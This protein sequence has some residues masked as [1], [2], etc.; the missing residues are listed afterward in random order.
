MYYYHEITNISILLLF[1]V[2]L[3]QFFCTWIKRCSKCHGPLCSNLQYLAV[4]LCDQQCSSMSSFFNVSMHVDFPYNIIQF[5]SEAS[6]TNFKQVPAW[7]LAL[8]GLGIVLGLATF[9]YKIMQVLGVKMTRLTN[10]RGF[11]VEL[12]AAITV[13]LGSRYGLPLSTT[14]CIVGAVTG[15]GILEGSKGFNAIL[16]VKFFLGWVAT[17][18]V[19][20]FTSAAFMAQGIYSPNFFAPD[21]QLTAALAA[22]APVSAPAPAP[23]VG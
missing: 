21:A 11:C 5:I 13:I 14:H 17:L 6:I 2:Q 16:L 7:I 23:I 15:I 18:I 22:A 12:A 9:G 1:I 10:S 8:G 3:C 4:Y 19:A 20:G